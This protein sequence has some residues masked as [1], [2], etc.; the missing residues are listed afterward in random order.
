MCLS[1]IFMVAPA[2]ANAETSRS[3]IKS[4]WPALD[5]A[6]KALAEVR[7]DVASKEFEKV[8]Q[9]MSAPSLIRGMAILGL[10]E[11]ALARKDNAAAIS[12][13]QRL[14][15]D[16]SM[17]RF[18]IDTANRRISETKRLEQGLPGR[19][20][21]AYRVQLPTLPE[22]AEMF[23]VAANG[24]DLADGSKNSPFRTLK[25]ARDAVR[26]FKES[27]GG[28]LPKGGVRI[29]IGGGSYLIQETFTLT[30]RDSGTKE[31]PVIYQAKPNQMPPTI[32]MSLVI[33]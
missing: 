21:A 10:A 2:G 6:A 12:R 17:P 24:S 32:G 3:V 28:M 5:M 20:P 18:H 29:L 7:L 19:D 15:A 8:S 22:P 1:I 16:S 23:Y 26:N 31:A 13:W 4:S 30:S 27:N 14:A 11:V 9:N 33:F 25:R